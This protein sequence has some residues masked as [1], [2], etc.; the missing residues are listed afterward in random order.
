VKNCR[1]GGFADGCKRAGSGSTVSFSAIDLSKAD[2]GL[3]G[4]LQWFGKRRGPSPFKGMEINVVRKPSTTQSTSPGKHAKG[5]TA[6]H[7]LSK[8]QATDVIQEGRTLVEKLADQVQPA[9]R[10]V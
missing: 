8:G 3:K 7:G 2:S 10:N 6:S 4:K 1:A 5:F 9:K